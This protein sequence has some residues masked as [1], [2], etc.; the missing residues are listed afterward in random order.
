M[1][2]L[3]S[4]RRLALAG[5][6]GA[7]LLAAAPAQAGAPPPDLNADAAGLMLRGYDPVAYFTDGRPT[8]GSAEFTATRGAAVY[9]FA[10]AANRDAFLADPAKYEPAYGGFCALGTSLG[11]KF[12]G[13]PELWR[14]V[15]G[16][17]Y[18]NVSPEAVAR[19]QE[20][21][22]GNIGKADEA[23]PKIKATPAT[24]LNAG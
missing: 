11:K 4:T 10:S 6:V 14:I 16:K 17:L 19:W 12:D 23:W 1:P 22:P 20:D 21:I 15:D 2:L 13:D 3:R 5:L 9:H 24:Q 18:L 7:A 8:P